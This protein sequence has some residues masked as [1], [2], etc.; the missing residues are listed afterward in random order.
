M[1]LSGFN[2]CVAALGLLLLAACAQQPARSIASPGDASA[3]LDRAIDYAGGQHAL[4]EARLLSWSGSATLHAGKRQIQIV[5]Q[6]LV[7]PFDRAY[8]DSWPANEGPQATRRMEIMPDGGWMVRNGQRQPM[9]VAMATHERLQYAVY[10]LMR[11]VTLRDPGATIALLP[12]DR[13]GRP[14]LRVTHP[15]AT[16]AELRFDADGR[17]AMLSNRVPAADGHGELA[18]VFRFEGHIESRG[19]VWPNRI[20]IEQEGQPYFELFLE[21][22]SVGR[23]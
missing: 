3:L 22:F 17:L 15:Q 4:T 23:E 9:D 13:D 1:T 10:G 20:T 19:V 2:R 11:L 6:T 8:S 12:A 7:L 18:Q 21:D 16:P 5:V 14:G